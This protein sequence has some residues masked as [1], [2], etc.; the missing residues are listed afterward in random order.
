[1]SS[2][3][4]SDRVNLLELKEWLRREFLSFFEEFSGKKVGFKSF[5]KKK[6][7][8]FKKNENLIY[9]FKD[10]YMGQTVNSTIGINCRL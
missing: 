10:D 6:S 4:V 9:S 5:N 3:L 8:Y 7:I 1:M 2:H